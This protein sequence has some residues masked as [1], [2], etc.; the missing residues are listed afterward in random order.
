MAHVVL[1][2][3][4]NWKALDAFDHQSNNCVSMIYLT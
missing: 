1:L 3:G 2:D 4:S